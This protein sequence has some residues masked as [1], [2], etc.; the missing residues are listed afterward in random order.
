MA[1]KDKF[2]IWLQVYDTKIHVRVDRDDEPL[3]RRAAVLATDRLN[4]YSTFYN[5]RK[6][7]TEI[8]YMALIDVGLMY[9]RERF[10]SDSEPFV[11]SMKKIIAEIEKAMS[12]E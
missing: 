1:D 10:R 9:E 5:G 11:K 3:Y 6:G 12:E 8:D 4:A 2:G 7:K